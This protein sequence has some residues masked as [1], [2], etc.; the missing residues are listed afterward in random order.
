MRNADGE[1]EQAD[2]AS[3]PEVRRD[4][5]RGLVLL[6]IRRVLAVPRAGP[7][8]VRLPG[9]AGR[10]GREAREG[11]ARAHG[12]QEGAGVVTM[13]SAYADFV[14]GKRAAVPSCGF[15]P[16]EVNPM[17]FGFQADIVRWACRKG[18]AAVFA[19][20]GLGKTAVQLEWARLVSERCGR[21]VLVLAPLAVAAQT[22]REGRKF[23]IAVRAVRSG[24]G[25]GEGP[26]V[27]VTNYEMLHR[28]D[29]AAFAGVVLDES[30]IIKSFT[31]KMRN[32]IISAFKGTPFRL[33]CTATPS[34]NDHMELGNHAEFLGAMTRAEMLAM[35]FVHDGGDT[36]KRRIKGHARGAF[37]DFVASWAVMVRRPSD[38][39]YPDDGFSLP[40][41]DEQIHVIESGVEAEGR[42][43]ATEAQGLME[44]SRARRSTVE[45]RCDFAAQLV[46]CS[47]EPWIVW[48]DRNDESSPPGGVHTGCGG[49]SRQRL[50]GGEGAGHGRL[51]RWQG[52]GGRH[53]AQHLRVGHELAALLEDGLRGTVQQ[54]R[55][56]LPGSAA[57]PPVRGSSVPRWRSTS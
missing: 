18:K 7:G 3:L 30:S 41:L 19:D 6:H 13:E 37:W 31:G 11:E 43:F 20:C 45:R 49:G 21:P 26:G 5:A 12:L 22:V 39:G 35:F 54:L 42:L 1:R 8:G 23:G 44:Q 15:E 56:V 29:P 27:F 53:Q 50:A 32:E 52:A 25:I 10:R 4:E 46:N 57:L 17:L 16:G 9:R 36:S 38:M 55:A 47:D 14:A 2:R 51:H 34:P 28:F 33:A 24:D 48:C 40:P